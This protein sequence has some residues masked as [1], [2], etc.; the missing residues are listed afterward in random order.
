M[1]GTM[2]CL[3]SPEQERVAMGIELGLLH[4]LLGI[5]SANDS[6]TNLAQAIDLMHVPV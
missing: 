3:E 1:P 4:V 5:E 6:I 2:A